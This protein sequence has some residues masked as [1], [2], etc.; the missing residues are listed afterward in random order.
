MNLL[1]TAVTVELDDP[2]IDRGCC[3]RSP[4]RQ[5]YLV[6]RQID[7]AGGVAAAELPPSYELSWSGRGGLKRPSRRGT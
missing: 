6:A 5:G 3:G 4:F 7:R 2:Y 1:D